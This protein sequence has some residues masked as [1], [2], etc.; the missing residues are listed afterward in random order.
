MKKSTQTI[1]QAFIILMST[2]TLCLKTT[3]AQVITYEEIQ[4]GYLVKTESHQSHE[5]SSGSSQSFVCNGNIVMA[6]EVIKRQL[7]CTEKDQLSAQWVQ[8]LLNSFAD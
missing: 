5:N 7:S 2:S 8:L 4:L 3:L 6:P 1:I